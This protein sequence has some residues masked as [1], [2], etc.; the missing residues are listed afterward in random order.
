MSQRSGEYPGKVFPVDAGQGAKAKS[1]DDRAKFLKALFVSS[2][3]SRQCF[4]SIC[5]L[6]YPEEQFGPLL[7]AACVMITTH[8]F[9]LR[10]TGNFSKAEF[11]RLPKRMKDMAQLIKG[12]NE[13][14]LAPF[15]EVLF[16]PP[17]PKDSTAQIARDYLKLRYNMLPGML[18]VYASHLE[19]FAKIARQG[20]K[21]LT[22]GQIVA[23]AV[24]NSVKQYTRSPRYE[25]LAE[26]LEQGCIIEAGRHAVP[27]YLTVDALAKLHQRWSGGWK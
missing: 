21:R 18:Y 14:F 11:N 10:D 23:I 16:M 13:T 6:G 20:W 27:K 2:P 1:G 24:L 15:N 22:T 4:R 8:D 9:P 25:E 7:W 19:R 17:I 3:H 12:L 26:L 5:E